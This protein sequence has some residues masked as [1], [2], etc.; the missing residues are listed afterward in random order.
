MPFIINNS[1]TD[2]WFLN[3]SYLLSSTYFLLSSLLNVSPALIH[4]ILIL[5]LRGEIIIPHP[6]SR[7]ENLF[8][9]PPL[10]PATWV[11]M[12]LANF[13]LFFWET[14]PFSSSVHLIVLGL[15][16]S[17]FQRRTPD[18]GPA[19]QSVPFG[20][21][22]EDSDWVR[23]EYVTHLRQWM[24]NSWAGALSLLWGG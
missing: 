15:T 2:Y 4:V 24:M 22:F 1:K 19:S 23:G 14:T 9:H 6:I 3:N 8:S 18:L 20:L 16:P 12:V 21:A 13:Y 11:S 17:W 7:W 5:T 10:L